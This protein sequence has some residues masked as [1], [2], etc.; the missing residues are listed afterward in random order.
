MEN[1]NNNTLATER[2]RRGTGF[3]NIGKTINA[4]SGNRLGSTVQS[5][6]QNKAQE[7]KTGLEQT[8]SGFNQEA[9]TNR[10]GTEQDTQER[11]TILNKFNPT[12]NQQFQDV[13]DEEVNK[14][15]RFRSGLYKGPQTLN[16]DKTQ[17]LRGKAQQAQSLGN[18]T[19]STGGRQELLKQ[20]V[21]GKDYTRGQQQLD[22]L[23]LGQ[24][25]ANQLKQSR[26]STL[27][28]GQN[29]N[30]AEQ[31]AAEQ[32]KQY[33]REAENFAQQTNTKLSDMFSTRDTELENTAKQRLGSAE[34]FQNRILDK[35]S[36]EEYLT[37]EE[38][39]QLGLSPEEAAQLGALQDISGAKFL[40]SA[41]VSGKQIGAAKDD[42]I[43]DLR[44][45]GYGTR[46]VYSFGEDAG[47]ANR[48]YEARQANIDKFDNALAT[49]DRQT[50][51]QTIIDGL[52]A[53]EKYMYQ[54]QGGI[55]G[56]ETPEKFAEYLLNTQSID[57]IK[58]N[59]MNPGLETQDLKQ[60]AKSDYGYNP[61]MYKGTQYTTRDVT[62]TIQGPE[63]MTI[64]KN[65]QVGQSL[66]TDLA[67]QL[68][69][70][71]VGARI[72]NLDYENKA[73]FEFE[74]YLKKFDPTSV[75][76]ETVAN[77]DQLAQ[78]N[79]L[80]R[81]KGQNPMFDVSKAGTANTDISLQQEVYDDAINKLFG[82]GQITIDPNTG[83]WIPQ[84]TMAQQII[85][86]G[87]NLAAMPFT[88]PTDA[89][90]SAL[91][92]KG[93]PAA[94]MV[95]FA[96]EAAGDLY[97]G[98]R[99]VPLVGN[100]LDLGFQKP[101]ELG[102]DAIGG[103]ANSVGKNLSKAVGTVICTEL[104]RQGIMSDEVYKKDVAYGLKLK[105][106]SPETFE[107]YQVWAKYVAKWMSKS[108]II[109][110]IIKPFGMA[111]ANNMAGNKNLLGTLILKVGIPTCKIIGKIYRRLK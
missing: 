18:M 6:V 31:G 93:T 109:T 3:T 73:D 72:D 102:V 105:E 41:T 12:E 13:N 16:Q 20:F 108:K 42:Y 111:W 35:L 59:Y 39:S 70:Y 90:T 89:L 79:A 66:D 5:G 77:Q 92:L 76:K 17:Q 97:E 40:R 14:F 21:G 10:I 49:G 62:G 25:G 52:P 4:N 29:I 110:A 37:D 19:Q 15:D 101:L 23:L 54:Y 83:N 94:D 8:Q 68:G 88:A 106:V 86:S 84:T 104:H 56:M 32:A 38:I 47:A 80:Q 24:T 9:Q 61:E 81:L 43:N 27:G 71:D 103:F 65:A 46:Q 64:L 33:G 87:V 45:S 85:S 100:M 48:F 96:G 107:G 55:P 67:R 30:E 57:S 22:N 98:L 34:E 44:G 1:N 36:K 78:L 99:E 53:V 91:G 26:R 69:L 28:L 75:T 82:E 2:N 60:L 51:I 11:E 74:R 50:A 63:L 95:G 58:K 7:V